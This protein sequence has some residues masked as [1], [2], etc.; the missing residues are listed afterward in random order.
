MWQLSL[1]PWQTSG[2]VILETFPAPQ[3]SIRLFL[4][5][6][7][8]SILIDC[9]CDLTHLLECVCP[10]CYSCDKASFAPRCSLKAFLEVVALPELWPAKPP[11]LSPA[12]IY[13]TLW[14]SRNVNV[15]P[16]WAEGT[17]DK[18]PVGITS[19]SSYT[20][21]QSQGSHTAPSPGALPYLCTAINILPFA[22]IGMIQLR[23]LALL[24]A[25]KKIVQNSVFHFHGIKISHQAVLILLTPVSISSPCV[26]LVTVIYF[27]YF[28]NCLITQVNKVSSSWFS[29][30]GSFPC[31]LETMLF[32]Q[33]IMVSNRTGIMNKINC[34]HP[35]AAQGSP[36]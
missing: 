5:K 19:S 7:L 13:K 35:L 34:L 32:W 3:N 14:N 23:R 24:L 8:Q 29:S 9:L 2:R 4:L 11:M 1:R 30:A 6:G 25:F 18:V 10:D 22:F 15:F 31:A 17:P 26:L 33:T 27:D 21:S 12:D 36:Q 16:G 28:S 20:G